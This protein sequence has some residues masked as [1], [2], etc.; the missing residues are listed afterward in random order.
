ML[1]FPE[2]L[3]DPARFGERATLVPG[4]VEVADIE[5]ISRRWRGDPRLVQSDVLGLTR[6]IESSFEDDPNGYGLNW[7]PQLP[8]VPRK[9]DTLY[10]SHPGLHPRAVLCLA[11][12]EFLTAYAGLVALTPP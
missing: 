8:P 4:M 12:V 11:W 7:K 10:D 5:G 9:I 3:P 2:Q 6:A 1:T